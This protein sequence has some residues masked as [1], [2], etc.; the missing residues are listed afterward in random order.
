M[1]FT[2]PDS[3]GSRRLR[4][5]NDCN[6]PAGARDGGRFGAN[7]DPRC[8]G[9]RAGAVPAETRP[10]E[11]TYSQPYPADQAS[12]DLLDE[13]LEWEADASAI[14]ERIVA[15]DRALADA[16]AAADAAYK[17]ASDAFEPL[18]DAYRDL[19]DELVA[20]GLEDIPRWPLTL[21]GS[22]GE[23]PAFLTDAQAR[24]LDQYNAAGRARQVAWAEVDRTANVKGASVT[25]Q[26]NAAI[27]LLTLPEPMQLSVGTRLVTA[28]DKDIHRQSL[29]HGVEFFQKVVND[30]IHGHVVPDVVSVDKAENGRA[31]ARVRDGIIALSPL[32]GGGTVAHELGHLL[33]A[34]TETLQAAIDF[35]TIR[36]GNTMDTVQLSTLLPGSGYKVD[37]V[38]VVGSD[39]AFSSPYAGKVYMGALNPPTK[40]MRKAMGKPDIVRDVNGR[41][42]TATEIVSMGLQYLYDDPAKFARRDPEWFDFTVNLIRKGPRAAMARYK[43]RMPTAKYGWQDTDKDRVTW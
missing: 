28:T 10:T 32:D 26:Y 3:A 15:N 7:S 35:R 33:E 43:D 23:A 42:Q 12:R 1:R 25:E 5:F 21:G 27:A 17:K 8:G 2:I 39:T 34:D 29:D 40:G 31:Y 30:R 37:E 20:A 13:G 16:R 6:L 9:S 38:T 11:K 36:L 14:R 22:R 24:L 18:D 4:E 19:R 41:P